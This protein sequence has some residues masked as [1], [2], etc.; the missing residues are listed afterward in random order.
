MLDTSME[1][2]FGDE[3][4]KSLADADVSMRRRLNELSESQKILPCMISAHT[5][6]KTLFNPV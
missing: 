5:H 1:V 3:M 4:D 2:W 6:R